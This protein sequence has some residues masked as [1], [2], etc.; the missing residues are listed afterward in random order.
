MAYGLIPG[1]WVEVVQHSPV[2]VVQVEN[3]ELALEDELASQIEVS[4]E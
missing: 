4:S 2:T 3:T 1:N